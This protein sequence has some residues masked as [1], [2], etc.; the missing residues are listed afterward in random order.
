M[1]SCSA[2]PSGTLIPDPLFSIPNLPLVDKFEI[3]EQLSNNVKSQSIDLRICDTCG[4]IQISDLVPE[5]LYSE[6]IYESSSSPDLDLHFEEYADSLLADTWLRDGDSILEIGINDGLLANKVLSRIKS[7]CYIGVDPSPQALTAASDQI[8][9]INTF[10]NKPNL[11]S[12]LPNQLFDVVI[13]NNV[14]S[15]IPNMSEALDLISSR[16]KDDGV[17]IFEIQSVSS[18]IDGLVFDYIYH[19]HI[20]YHSLS[21]LFQ[22]L[23][24]SGLHIINATSRPVKG[25]SYRVF[26][27]KYPSIRRGI[28]ALDLPYLLYKENIARVSD[29]RSWDLLQDYLENIERSLHQFIKQEKAQG[30]LIVDMVRVLQARYLLTILTF[31]ATLILLLMITFRAKVD[32]LLGTAIPIK[33]SSSLSADSSVICRPG[34]IINIISINS[35]III[36]SY[37]FLLPALFT[38]TEFLPDHYESQYSILDEYLSRYGRFQMGDMSSFTWN[39]DP[40]RLLFVLSRYKAV[41]SMLDDETH[42][43]EVGC[44]DAFGSRIVKQ[45]V[46]D[47]TVSDAD[48]VLINSAK[49]WVALL[50]FDCVHPISSSRL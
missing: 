38:M 30:R 39:R 43:L 4:T 31:K 37:P 1:K 45:F 3:S 44:G 26:A 20:F 22:L 12:R 40:K 34:A 35:F 7:H 29:P 48:Q 46:K 47:L 42:V 25:G 13:A 27:A 21:S 16:L 36:T 18:V 5:E 24:L 23:S 6:Y 9:V 19:E 33:N 11:E 50:E 14:L 41:A 32:F 17:L 49:G 15:H 2:C 8:Q 28:P 10:F